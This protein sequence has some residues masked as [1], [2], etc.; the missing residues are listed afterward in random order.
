MRFRIVERRALRSARLIQ[1]APTHGDFGINAEVVARSESE[2]RETALNAPWHNG[3]SAAE[4]GARV[5]SIAY[6]EAF[7]IP[8]FIRW[9]SMGFKTGS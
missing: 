9:T 3:R 8:G 1:R 2:A 7:D 6:G 5:E 4:N